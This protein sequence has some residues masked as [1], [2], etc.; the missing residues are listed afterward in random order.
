MSQQLTVRNNRR[1]LAQRSA[2]AAAPAAIGAAVEA[3]KAGVKAL[4]DSNL[5][6]GRSNQMS[7][8][9]NMSSTKGG[10][11]KQS[12]GRQSRQGSKQG[13]NS[14]PTTGQPSPVL[15]SVQTQSLR[16]KIKDVFTVQCNA[17]GAF[18]PS[19]SL[20]IASNTGNYLLSQVATRLSTMGSMYRNY[21]LHTV[22]ITWIP[23]QA[24]TTSGSVCM[25]VDQAVNVGGATTVQGVYHH[26]PS[27]LADIK[28]QFTITWSAK[29][30]MKN[31]PRYTASGAAGT[32]GPSEDELSWGVFQMYGSSN[33]T[34]SVAVGMLEFDMDVTFLN[35]Y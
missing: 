12:S 15:R 11:R 13:A 28:K 35:P 31:D 22:K 29:N 1:A 6:S 14:M 7:T 2:V 26:F 30:A 10:K 3:L 32:T 17:T 27:G 9:S 21:F 19:I 16:T 33:L 20:A 18:S 24:Y 23:Y 4:K 5:S 25:G 8:N 34:S